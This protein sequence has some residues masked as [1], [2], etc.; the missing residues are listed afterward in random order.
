MPLYDF[1]CE[2]C[3]AF[4]KWR[5]LAEADSPMFCPTCEAVAKRIFSPP[6]LLTGSLRLKGQE[7]QEPQVVKRSQEAKPQRNYEHRGGRPWMISH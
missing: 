3:G 1:R 4:E 6:M 7:N 5:S 2:T